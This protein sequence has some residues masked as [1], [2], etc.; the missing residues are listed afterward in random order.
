[1]RTACSVAS[2]SPRARAP[3]SRLRDP[4]LVG[5]RGRLSG[6]PGF[7][8]AGAGRAR[9]GP[10]VRSARRP[11]QPISVTVADEREGEDEQ[12]D[13]DRGDEAVGPEIAPD[14]V[15]QEE[16]RRPADDG[17]RDE[18][19]D[20]HVG[21]PAGETAH[22]VRE[23]RDQ[24]A[25]EQRQADGV[26]VDRV[27][28]RERVVVDDALDVRPDWRDS[29]KAT[30]EPTVMPTMLYSVPT[31]AP[32]GSRRRPPGS[33]SGWAPGSPGGLEPNQDER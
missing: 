2:G 31:T 30:V 4:A 25:D 7:V 9:R 21:E 17:D 3:G 27:E 6:V 32:R 1:M 5:A 18:L 13:T 14:D 15:R 33:A 24:E 28:A 23:V 16:P 22:V 8:C 11:D 20:R 26:V 29:Q 12:R 10:P 19:P